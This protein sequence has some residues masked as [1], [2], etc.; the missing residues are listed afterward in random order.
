MMCPI[1]LYLV[2]LWNTQYDIFCYNI[3]D[4][5]HVN[6]NISTQSDDP[7][8]MNANEYN[9]FKSYL[10]SYIFILEIFHNILKYVVLNFKNA[11]TYILNEIFYNIWKFL[12]TF[13]SNSVDC[14]LFTLQKNE[15]STYHHSYNIIV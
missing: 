6:K 10:H 5:K 2:L 15:N 12:F 14:H 9:M 4:L 11:S 3:F 13:T 1:V 7:Y 8:N